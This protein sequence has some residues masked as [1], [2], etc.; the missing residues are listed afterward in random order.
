MQ[1][2]H[3]HDTSTP[4]PVIAAVWLALEDEQAGLAEVVQD[5][6]GQEPYC[7]VNW[8]EVA[9]IAI[10]A[11]EQVVGS[12]TWTPCSCEQRIADAEIE[13]AATS[14]Y[15]HEFGA[16]QD[17][18]DETDDNKAYWREVGA[19]YLVAAWDAEMGG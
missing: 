4:Q 10:A 12:P 6:P 1:D 9:R 18:A 17:W 13:A 8:P 11:Y 3:T 19:G 2:N 14:A 7:H 5:Y 15:A 16:A